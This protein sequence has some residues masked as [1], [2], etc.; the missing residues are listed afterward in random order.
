MCYMIPSVFDCILNLMLFFS[1]TSS[2]NYLE[3]DSC[4]VNF[5][6]PCNIF[7]SSLLQLCIYNATHL[8]LLLWNKVKKNILLLL[9]FPTLISLKYSIY[10]EVVI[11]VIFFSFVYT[12][13]LFLIPLTSSS[14]TLTVNFF[15]GIF[16]FQHYYVLLWW[17]RRCQRF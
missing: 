6:A 11:V 15:F 1:M 3:N 16:V 2:L 14:D 8:I 7:F 10:F 13:A 9:Y 4:R 12:C 17:R 5:R